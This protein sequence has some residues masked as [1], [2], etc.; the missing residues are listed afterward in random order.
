M[1]ASTDSVRAAF[2]AVSSNASDIKPFTP[3]LTLA[4]GTRV[5]QVA[6]SS[7]ENYLVIS[8][9]TGGG[10]AVYDVHS[11]MQGNTQSAFELSTD[12]VSL[13][14]LTPNPATEKAELFAV[15][16]TNG[17]LLIADM[18]SRQF[19]SGLTGQIL[20]DGVS[21]VSWSKLGKQ[22]VAGLGNGG[23]FQMTP[24][25]EGKGEIPK[26]AGIEGDQHGTH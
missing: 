22:L 12:G 17:Q 25:G 19:S 10:L 21:C 14:A 7:D 23:G 11:I 9:E 16:L 6:F 15:I 1:I 5:S 13:R 24:N 18:K 26:P 8:A 2:E 4:I 3:Q 20:K